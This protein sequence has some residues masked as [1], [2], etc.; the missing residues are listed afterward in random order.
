MELIKRIRRMQD[1]TLYPYSDKMAQSFGMEIVLCDATGTVRE[2]VGEV[3]S[4]GTH[5]RQ[6]KGSPV[7]EEES[8]ARLATKSKKIRKKATPKPPPQLSTLL[9]EVEPDGSNDPITG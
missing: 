7:S 1:G 6:F 9:D 3:G 2:V 8:Q 4:V 5:G